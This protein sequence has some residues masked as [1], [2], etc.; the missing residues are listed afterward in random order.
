M[1]K[2]VYVVRLQNDEDYVALFSTLEEVANEMVTILQDNEDCYLPG[3]AAQ[4]IINRME[5][6]EAMHNLYVFANADE[7]FPDPMDI[8]YPFTVM[9]CYL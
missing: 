4:E 5:E 3:E 9:K 8:R 7:F 6:R 2:T 1:K